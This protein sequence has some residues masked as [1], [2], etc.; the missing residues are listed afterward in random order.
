MW[1]VPLRLDYADPQIQRATGL[2]EELAEA[3]VITF[4]VVLAMLVIVGSLWLA[5]ML[6]IDD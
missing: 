3:A 1:E 5:V 6:A 4:W 2:R